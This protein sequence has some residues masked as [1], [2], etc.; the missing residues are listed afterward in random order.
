[1]KISTINYNNPKQGYF[2]LFLSDC[3]DMLDPSA[4]ILGVSGSGKSMLMKMFILLIILSTTKDQVLVYDPEGEYEPLVQE[5]GGVSLPI[6]A[7]SDVH[8]N[9]MDMIKGY[10]DKNSIVD[11]SQF[12]LSLYERI[13]DDRYIIGPKEKSILDRYV[14]NQL[15]T[16]R[17]VCTGFFYGKNHAVKL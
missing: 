7:G 4:F 1:M 13:S 9:A 5:F 8:L 2:P 3:L 16:E 15:D 17:R 6:S 11:K 12:V 14:D 10:G